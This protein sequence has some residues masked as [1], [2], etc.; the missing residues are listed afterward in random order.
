MKV[1]ILAGGKA[2]RLPK[3][4]QDKPKILLEIGGQTILE[5]QINLFERHGF[6]DIRLSLGDKASAVIDFL[7]NDLG[8][9]YEYVLEPEPLDTGGA[10]KF[11]SRDL[12][13]PFMVANGDIISN[14]DLNSFAAS[15]QR[16]TASLV[17][18][19]H[20]KNT[21]FGLL[22]LD[23]AK[24]IKNFLEKPDEPTNGHVNVGF[25]ILEP[26]FFNDTPIG[27]FS[28]EYEIFPRLAQSDRLYGFLHDG[29]WHDLGTERRLTYVR[30]LF[31]D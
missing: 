3:Q 7:D 22:A 18:A 6:P 15:H 23:E 28:I 27:K 31:E 13:E 25:Y 9:R 8:G 2:T 16:G 12:K 10:I 5:H 26:H 14:V 21:D 1:I 30:S 4:H 24:K 19:Y 29:Y 17:I 20:E 11:A